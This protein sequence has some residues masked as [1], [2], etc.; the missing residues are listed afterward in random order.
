MYSNNT[1]D[2]RD[3]KTL[4]SCNV[5]EFTWRC[6]IPRPQV[7]QNLPI[8]CHELPEEN[9]PKIAEAVMDNAIYSTIV[10]RGISVFDPSGDKVP[11]SSELMVLA[12]IHG[13]P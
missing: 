8:C 2:R 13:L 7:P 9:M 3:I 5:T 12:V 6:E 10:G 4:R 11:D 1:A